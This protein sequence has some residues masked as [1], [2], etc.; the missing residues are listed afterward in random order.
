MKALPVALLVA[1]AVLA[2]CGSSG[3]SSTTASQAAATTDPTTKA[4]EQLATIQEG[5][6]PDASD[7]LV[8]QFI[9]ALNDL[10]PFC[11][12]GPGQL[13]P[14]IY[15]A[16]QDLEKNNRPA[17]LLRV[18]QSLDTLVTGTHASTPRTTDCA[19]SLAVYLVAAE[20]PGGAP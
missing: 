20:A 8:Q 3:G 1:A 14:E 2:G 6:T 9:S 17:T 12:Q 7:P 16:Q 5:G 13:A 15:N 11:S 4:A 18:A 10:Q 19:S